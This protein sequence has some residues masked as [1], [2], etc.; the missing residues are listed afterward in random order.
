MTGDFQVEDHGSLILL[1]PMTEAA[2]QWVADF[3]P[4]EAIRFGEAVVVEPRYISNIVHGISGDGLA[5][6]LG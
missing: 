3:I 6:T 2:E 1:R 5:V 4:A